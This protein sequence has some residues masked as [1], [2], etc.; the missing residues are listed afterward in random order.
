ME[1]TTR[2]FFIEFSGLINKRIRVV[3]VSGKAY[4]GE[5]QG[6]DHN[7]LSVCLVNA[8]DHEGVKYYRVFILGPQ[9]AELY[10]V[11]KPFDMRGLAEEISK[12]FPQPG[13]VKLHE[14]AGVIS[15]LD[16]K[17]TVTEHG[18]EGEGPLAEKIRK[19]YDAYMQEKVGVRG[20]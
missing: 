10:E 17:I 18:V 20:A 15:V 5:L 19:V 7:T 6:F 11:E 1:S 16:N 2:K 8:T 12:L 9:L 3:T 13:Q 4:E 14:P